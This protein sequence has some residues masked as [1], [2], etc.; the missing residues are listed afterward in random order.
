MSLRQISCNLTETNQRLVYH[1]S[2]F[3]DQ[4]PPKSGFKHLIIY[5]DVNKPHHTMLV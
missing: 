4:K 2:L 1:F 3:A 5:V